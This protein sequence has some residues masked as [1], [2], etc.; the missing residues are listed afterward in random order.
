MSMDSEHDRSETASNEQESPMFAARPIWEERGRK[1]RGLGRKAAPA[2]PA[3]TISPEPRTFA[4]ERDY[5]EPMALDT[6]VDSPRDRSMADP[7]MDQP[8]TTPAPATW[9]AMPPGLPTC[10][11]RPTAG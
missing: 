10:P 2:A 1:R 7:A 8:M 5:D 11:R 6:P 9:P 3:A 4:S